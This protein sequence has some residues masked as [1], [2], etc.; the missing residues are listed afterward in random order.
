MEAECLQLDGLRDVDQLALHKADD[1]VDVNLCPNS[2]EQKQVSSKIVFYE[3]SRVSETAKN[4]ITD[5]EGV[6]SSCNPSEAPNLL[7]KTSETQEVRTYISETHSISQQDKFPIVCP[8][9]ID[10]NPS[11][12]T[13][14]NI[15]NPEPL[16]S[17]ENS[18]STS[19][20]S[21]KSISSSIICN[22][23]VQEDFN[24][25]ENFNK[26]YS[27][28]PL[29]ISSIPLPPDPPPVMSRPP[30]NKPSISIETSSSFA[31]PSSI[32]PPQ[33]K[34]LTNSDHFKTTSPSTSPTLPN[35]AT[36]DKNRK[37]QKSLNDII[38]KMHS[39][40]SQ[41]VVT[42]SNPLSRGDNPEQTIDKYEDGTCCNGEN[43]ELVDKNSVEMAG[44]DKKCEDLNIADHNQSR[45]NMNNVNEDDTTTINNDITT[46]N[47]K[48]DT[49]INNNS[50]ITKNKNDNITNNNDTIT[51]N[52]NY[53][54][55]IN[56]KDIDTHLNNIDNL[57]E[58]S[59]VINDED[60]DYIDMDDN[61]QKQ[62]IMNKEDDNEKLEITDK[63]EE[64]I[65][66]QND[67]KLDDSTTKRQAT[68]PLMIGD[69][70]VCNN[71]NDHFEG[72][73]DEDDY[74]KLEI[75]VG[76]D[77]KA[78]DNDDGGDGEVNNKDE[79][80]GVE[81]KSNDNDHHHHNGNDQKNP[82][83]DE[84]CM[85]NMRNDKDEGKDNK[86]MSGENE[87][88]NDDRNNCVAFDLSNSSKEK[89][90]LYENNDDGDYSNVNKNNND[91]NFAISKNMI[92]ESKDIKEVDKIKKKS[93]K[94]N[95]KDNAGSEDVC[96][97]VKPHLIKV[98]G[99][100]NNDVKQ[101]GNTDE[102]L[103]GE[104]KGVVSCQ[105]KVS[106]TSLE[107]HKYALYNKYKDW[108]D[109][110]N[111]A[112]NLVKTQQDVGTV[113]R[114][115]ISQKASVINSCQPPKQQYHSFIANN[116]HHS[117]MHFQQHQFMQHQYQQGM[118]YHDSYPFQHLQQQPHN[119]Q[120][121]KNKQPQQQ[122][123]YNKYSSYKESNAKT[124]SLWKSKYL[125]EESPT[126]STT[127]SSIFQLEACI[128]S[129]S[130]GMPV[131]EAK[132]NK[133]KL[134]SD[135]Q[136]ELKAFR[137]GLKMLNSSDDGGKD[138]LM[139]GENLDVKAK[140][141]KSSKKVK[142]E[143]INNL[144]NDKGYYQ[145]YQ[146]E[147][148][149]YQHST[150]YNLPQPS[151]NYPNMYNNV[152]LN[153]TTLPNNPESYFDQS[154]MS[155][156]AKNSPSKSS[157]KNKKPPKAFIQAPN[158]LPPLNFSTTPSPPMPSIKSKRGHDIDKIFEFDSTLKTFKCLMCD[159][160]VKRK[161]QLGKHLHNNHQTFL[162]TQCNQIC[163]DKNSLE[164]H[165]TYSHPPKNTHMLCK[166]CRQHVAVGEWEKHQCADVTKHCS[167][168]GKDFRNSGSFKNH[169]RKCLEGS[170]INTEAEESNRLAQKVSKEDE[171]KKVENVCAVANI[172]CETSSLHNDK[173]SNE[174]SADEASK[175]KKKHSKNKTAKKNKKTRDK[176]CSPPRKPTREVVKR[177]VGKKVISYVDEDEDFDEANI[178][179]PTEPL[180]TQAFDQAMEAAQKDEIFSQHTEHQNTAC[181]D[182]AIPPS[183]QSD[184]SIHNFSDSTSHKAIEHFNIHD[185]HEVIKN[186]H[187]DFKSLIND[188]IIHKDIMEENEVG[189]F[190]AEIN[191]TQRET[192]KK[193][194]I[195]CDDMFSTDNQSEK[196]DKN[197]DE[198]ALKG[199]KLRKSYVCE[200]CPK[201]YRSK[202]SLKKH[203]LKKHE[204]VGFP[205]HIT[206]IF[207][208]D[209]EAVV[210]KYSL[211]D[212]EDILAE[213]KSD[214]E[215]RECGLLEGGL[216]EELKGFSGDEINNQVLPENVEISKFMPTKIISK[217]SKS[218]KKSK[219]KKAKTEEEKE[220]EK[221]KE[222]KA[223]W[224]EK[225]DSL[226]I[227]T[228]E[229]VDGW[230][231]CV[232]CQKKFKS[233]E[234]VLKHEETHS[235]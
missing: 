81:I 20:I 39:D 79:N 152:L 5:F 209:F 108:Q 118:Y 168:C 143:P 88:K 214:K 159:Y 105:Q 11:D 173:K 1:V 25:S 59:R 62:N 56:N 42:E 117:S 230:Y 55:T 153:N 8:D 130:H 3:T 12:T 41:K 160:K 85:K 228:R 100:A 14:Q 185:E 164:T 73:D 208:C 198:D 93:E 227:P 196:R 154:E 13:G 217:K 193:M 82:D 231:V 177:E 210:E 46:T 126:P 83:D 183:N 70:E 31:S 181:I 9:T 15:S 120:S 6:D 218:F 98:D 103:V 133:M 4:E 190:N 186:E 188:K 221:E 169:M 197:D 162:C 18:I 104:Q 77:G 86:L 189:H 234:R 191:Q 158:Q 144:V 136:K 224:K 114:S 122:Q 22:S 63:K 223:E 219:C 54:T 68:S 145:Q 89:K 33:D 99:E 165:L 176:K 19:N 179:Q 72:N 58:K 207:A 75:D 116:N 57:N 60:K 28:V 66:L 10:E 32:S 110:D 2:I 109:E 180:G 170:K 47:I 134:N 131:A 40:F 43:D 71:L 229:M 212:K 112:L 151:N 232:E 26:L 91:I 74:D 21:D 178:P 135:I 215:E 161:N 222:K 205:S 64:N 184:P 34:E 69:N 61:N 90:T 156:T 24:K 65:E 225:M 203:W 157:S 107:Q 115:S 146:H 174:D 202:Q 155:K 192:N 220:K 137:M 216:K 125:A 37:K 95:E 127:A 35:T 96:H 51:N 142:N 84:K 128:K 132:K 30:P 111:L 97:D 76:D 29:S 206:P 141:K 45:A 102:T 7:H 129:I 121:E 53:N 199:K 139:N 149:K 204:E 226:V 101:G 119:Y 201:M 233:L 36:K 175:N 44:R 87:K 171:A 195:E 49:T 92:K 38:F 194:S 163:E 182:E 17:N 23:I 67:G 140:K 150:P 187:V 148:Y 166:K 200:H 80:E 78:K 123:H 167:C 94:K 138:M 50:T 27:D 147:Q 211:T 48:N 172:E 235:S 113:S 16:V 124:K 106:H 213:N 52:I